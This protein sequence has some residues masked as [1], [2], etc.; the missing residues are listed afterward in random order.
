M[1]TNPCPQVRWVS[2][3]DSSGHRHMEMRWTV[4]TKPTVQPTATPNTLRAA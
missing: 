2:V 3:V 4:P 1:R